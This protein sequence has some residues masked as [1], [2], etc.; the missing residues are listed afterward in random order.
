MKPGKSTKNS[1]KP[2][3]T[4]KIQ[5]TV[6]QTLSRISSCKSQQIC[7]TLSFLSFF[8]CFSYI[9]FVFESASEQENCRTQFEIPTKA[10][11]KI[12]PQNS[13]SSNKFKVENIK[14]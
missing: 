9:K 3:N 2:Q 12:F 4:T 13:K 5:R 6:Y 7:N 10:P 1:T 14:T 11:L 8:F